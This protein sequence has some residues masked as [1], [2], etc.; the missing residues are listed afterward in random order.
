MRTVDRSGWRPIAEGTIA[1]RVILLPG[2]GSDEVFV[3]A[4][5][6]R[7]LAVLGL[8]LVTP[9]PE[10]GAAVI[11]GYLA[12]LDA[13]LPPETAGRD[14]APLVGGVSLGAQV[15]ARWAARRAALGLPGPAGLL[16]ALPAWTGSAGRAPAAV[17]ARTTAEALCR[18]GLG[19]TLAQTRAA[20]PVW[21]GDELARAWT[22][23]GDGLANSFTTAAET[24][25][26]APEELTTLRMPAGLV[27]LADDPVHPLQV[28]QRWGA[29]LPRS[30]LVTT[31]LAATG[32]DPETLGRAATLAWL[33]A[34]SQ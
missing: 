3:T 2:S 28:A 27:G 6:R 1:R 9:R 32:R 20:A 10:R 5:F 8:R 15:A 16:L 14:A 18:G 22:R 13:A 11:T 7:P 34:V 17:A 25:G 12:A 33:R 24:P 19:A 26:P 21:L 23:H 4:A 29:L 30:A 31:T